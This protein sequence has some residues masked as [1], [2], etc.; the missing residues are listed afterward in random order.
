MPTPSQV[1]PLLTLQSLWDTHLCWVLREGM[2]VHC[3]AHSQPKQDTN[4]NDVPEQRRKL[5]LREIGSLVQGH[6]PSE[7]SLQ[8]FFFYFFSYTWASWGMGVAQW[9]PDMHLAKPYTH[10]EL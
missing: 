8:S 9:T 3:P 4:Y 2:C 10:E 5:Q 6:I 1:L 7:R